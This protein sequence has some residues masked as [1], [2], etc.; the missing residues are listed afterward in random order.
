MEMLSKMPPPP[1][2]MFRHP[3]TLLMNGHPDGDSP[4]D[5]TDL[6][7]DHGRQGVDRDSVPLDK[8]QVGGR[9]IAQFQN[10]LS[11]AKYAFLLKRT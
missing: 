4:S 3:Q 7:P 8:K 6:F 11:L 9:T 1:S 10:E 2:R 5:D